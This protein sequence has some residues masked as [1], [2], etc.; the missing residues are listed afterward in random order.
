MKIALLGDHSSQPSHRE[1][2]ALIPRLHEEL[3]ARAVWVAT[4]SGADITAFDGIW[5][6]PGSPYADD[7]AVLA[8]LTVARERGIPMLGTCGGLQYA[9]IEFVRSVLAQPAT[10]TES[11]GQA[12]DN[13]VTALS[14]SLRGESRM[15]VPV[16]GTRFAEWVPE[17]FSGM[18]YCSYAPTPEVIARLE[19]AGVVVGANAADAGAEVLDFPDHP[20]YVATL[21]QPHIGASTG[22]PLHPLIRRFVAALS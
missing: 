6:V 20:F 22:A 19:A 12:D 5:L 3:H 4:D 15:V 8:A 18:H 17:P 21:F 10:H 9:V 13:V 11:N 16:P 1:L 14:C 2:D 7:G